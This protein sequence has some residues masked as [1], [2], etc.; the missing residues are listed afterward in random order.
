MQGKRPQ[1]QMLKIPYKFPLQREWLAETGAF[2]T[3]GRA[4]P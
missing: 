2:Q 1:A 3:A 4:N